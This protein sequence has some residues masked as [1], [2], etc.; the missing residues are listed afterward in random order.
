MNSLKQS[1]LAAC[2]MGLAGCGSFQLASGVMPVRP[3]TQ[4]QMQ[5]D[6]LAC[7]DRAKLEAN[8]AERQAGNF[9]AGMT[10]VGV[11]IAIEAEKAKQREVF[12]TCMEERGY[13]V[14]PVGDDKQ[15]A[16]PELKK[17]ERLALPPEKTSD[18]L[19][20]LKKLKDAHDAGLLTDEEYATKRKAVVDTL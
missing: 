8:T 7:K 18:K 2:L 17:V 16:K 11:P 3:K 19:D 1:L 10:L 4:E 6:T 9:I 5:L 20:T 15:P 12:K 14:N 13:H